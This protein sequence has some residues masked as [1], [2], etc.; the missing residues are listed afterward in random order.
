LLHGDEP[1]RRDGKELVQ[2][3]LAGDDRRCFF[4]GDFIGASPL[5]IE[6]VF[7]EQEYLL[8]VEEAYPKANLSF[9]L[10]EVPLHSL[11]AKVEACLRRQSMEFD[12]SRPAQ[13]LRERILES[14]DKLPENVCN[15]IAKMFDTINAVFSCS[16]D[17]RTSGEERG[18]PSAKHRVNDRLLGIALRG[19]VLKKT[20]RPTR[21]WL[22][23]LTEASERFEGEVPTD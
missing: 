12:K 2:K 5:Q 1:G 18:L 9:E 3:M 15:I 17:S 11:V 21:S 13:V 6:D 20:D 7:P 19:R 4:I 16:G 14:P 8:A 23:R 10:H 22:R